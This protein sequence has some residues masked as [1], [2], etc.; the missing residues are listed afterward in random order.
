MKNENKKYYTAYE[1]RYKRH[2]RTG[3]VGQATKV[4]VR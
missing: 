1:E 2:I 3:S 4:I